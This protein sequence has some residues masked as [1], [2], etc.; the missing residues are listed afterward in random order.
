MK[1]KKQDN[2]RITRR[3]Y[4]PKVVVMAVE[5]VVLMVALSDVKMVASLARLLVEK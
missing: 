1:E 2:D 3:I 4:V 5:K